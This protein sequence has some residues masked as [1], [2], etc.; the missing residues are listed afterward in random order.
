MTLEFT[1]AGFDA[2]Q[3][4]ITD[5]ST[6]I[7]GSATS[8]GTASQRLQV[9][10][11]A[12]VS[13]S[14]GVGI[15]NPTNRFVVGGET[16]QFPQQLQVLSTLHATSRR[17]AIAI[18]GTAGNQNP[19]WQILQDTVGNG[20]KDF[21]IYSTAVSQSLFR[22]DTTGNSI[23]Q[24][25]PLLVGSATS[26]G[27]ASQALQVTGGAYVSGSVGIG[28]TNPTSK[29]EVLDGPAGGAGQL[30]LRTTGD[31]GIA[32]TTV[33]LRLNDVN[34]NAAYFGFGG[35][36]NQ[37]D[38]WNYK[39]GPIR[40]GTNSTEAVRVD[41]SGNVGI[42]TSAI[43]AR[44]HVLPTTTGIAGLFSGTTSADLV[45]ITQD[46]SG[47]AIRVDDQAGGVTPF[48]VDSQGRVGISTITASAALTIVTTGIASDGNSQIYLNGATS[49]RI[50]FAGVGVAAPTTVGTS[51]T[52]RSAG[53]KIV[54]YPT[55]TH[56]YAFGVESGHQWSSIP[57][58]ATGWKWYGGAVGVATL[59]VAGGLTLS[60]GLTV[61]TNSNIVG[62]FTNATLT[63]RTY[64]I[65]KTT[66]SATTVGAIPNGTATGSAFYAFNNSTPTNA[67]YCG[68]VVDST[69]AYL[70]SARTGTGAYLP[71]YIETTDTTRVA[72]TT[73]GNVG[74]G[75]TNPGSSLQVVGPSAGI[76][77]TDNTGAIGDLS[78]TG[79]LI[80]QASS[81][82]SIP[83][84]GALTISNGSVTALT[85]LT[86]G[87]VGIKTTDAGAELDVQGNLRIRDTTGTATF[88]SPGQ[89]AIKDNT[90]APFISFH[91]A[92]GVRNAY[93][94]STD[95][96]GFFVVQEDAFPLVLRTELTQPVQFETASI[97]RVAISTGGE[98]EFLKGISVV[99]GIATIP[100]VS[101]TATTAST[102]TTTGALTVAGGVGIAASAHVGGDV[103][104]RRSAT[105]VLTATYTGT[106]ANIATISAV[107]NIGVVTFAT[108]GIAATMNVTG[109]LPGQII[110]LFVTNP[111][112]AKLLTIQYNGTAIAGV[113]I[114]SASPAQGASFAANGTRLYRFIAATNNP[115]V[116]AGDIKVVGT[117]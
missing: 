17:A 30:R 16:I 24:Y 114:A 91:E 28:T 46:G 77:I 25:Y 20:T 54:L 90:S 75:I 13:G 52:T 33:F 39:N 98:T 36:V 106:P 15:T 66:N 64:F 110:E 26:T 116:V 82:S 49:N 55:T 85:A 107:G 12:Y 11:G 86:S 2:F 94:Q 48:I 61:G 96:T 117:T 47:N 70:R 63:A 113:G 35:S 93:I 74:I 83:P 10:G 88:T 92:A 62:D 78:S 21:A 112:T 34:G 67:S 56:D 99:A 76:R 108:T 44:L 73:T 40:L 87:N 101:V 57:L 8:T 69:A 65:T 51:G 32:N 6:V 60:G 5:V 80:N 19:D 102:S 104:Y 31:V 59:G 89:I 43:G 18:G 115:A 111:T 3:N 9:T 68:P 53:T 105:A 37:L 79:W 109:M 14:V 27:T 1:P 103:D 50:D 29:L 97:R 81:I 71:L 22:I 23:F 38:I 41:A 58:S 95:T 45:R 4:N 42:G 84:A 72:I 100:T 7:I